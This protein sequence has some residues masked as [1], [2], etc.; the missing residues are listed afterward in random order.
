MNT[1]PLRWIVWRCLAAM[2]AL[3]VATSATGEVVLSTSAPHAAAGTLLELTLTITNDS[4]QPLDLML[5]SPMHVRFETADHVAVGEFLPEVSGALS[6]EPGRFARVRLR[7]T[8]PAD[9][10]GPVTLQPTGL[11]T[12]AIVVQ[13][14]EPSAPAA[15]AGTPAQE[16]RPQDADLTATLVD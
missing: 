11:S 2:T 1:E 15:L 3:S 14:N 16:M 10:R 13:L 8:A 7:G 6:I 4:Q 12:N 5:S 9:L